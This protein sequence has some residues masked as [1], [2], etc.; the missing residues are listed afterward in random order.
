MPEI[1]VSARIGSAIVQ[2]A[3]ARGADAARLQREA[4][5]DATVGREPDAR[6]SIEVEDRLWEVAAELTKD[7]HF[8]LHA[9]AFLRPGAF[10]VLDYAVRTA[11]TLRAAI[12][13]LARY[14]RLVHSAAVFHVVDAADASRVRIE[15]AFA[16]PGRRPSRHAS[17][18]TIAS[19]VVIGG[20]ISAAPLHPLAIELPHPPPTSDA[21]VYEEVFGVRP[22]F[23]AAAGAI[24][25]AREE[26]DRPCPAA[27]PMLSE[28]ILR[29]AN[30]LLAAR[31]DPESSFAARVRQHLVGR[32]AEG[33]GSVAAMARTLKLSE[34]TFQR[35][36]AAEGL[37]FDVLLDEL[38]HELALR[39]LGDPAMAIGE[40]AYLLGYAEPSSF[41]RAFKRWTG[42]TPAEARSRAA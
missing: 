40:V 18:F 8:G 26:L 1:E 36:L 21:A 16:V 34:R 37:T 39:Y 38:R 9:A 15:H 7:V 11:P 28:I 2:I 29:Q 19:V 23:G 17:E 33:D 10:D 4:G 20:Q 31:P 35:R 25:L 32:L 6:I 5:F 30:A 14:N 12:E 42:A 3:V 27:D 22:R 13:R 41:H 24:E